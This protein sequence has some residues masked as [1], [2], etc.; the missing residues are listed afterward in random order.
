MLARALRLILTGTL[1][2]SAG[3]VY[4]EPDHRHR[5]HD[6]YENDQ[7]E[8]HCYDTEYGRRCRPGGG[9][10]DQGEDEQD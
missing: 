10:N 4:Y 5:D 1:L 2:L 9:E 8:R 7:G 3:C 6:R